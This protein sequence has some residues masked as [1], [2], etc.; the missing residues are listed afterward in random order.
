MAGKYPER[1]LIHL[2]NVQRVSN[3]AVD[4]RGLKSTTW[5]DSSTNVKTRLVFQSEQEN[6]DGRN[7]VIQSWYAYFGG[8][9]DV[10]SSDRLYEPS[11]GKYFEIESIRKHQNRVGRD[12]MVQASLL[13]RE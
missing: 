13:Y 7:T 2:V 9:V 5:S 4:S 8:D 10:K 3:T 6:R 11:S 12:F 1:L